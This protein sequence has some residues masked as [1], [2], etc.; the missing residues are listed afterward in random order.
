V[1]AATRTENEDRNK[2]TQQIAQ[3]TRPA[4]RPLILKRPGAPQWPD[5]NKQAKFIPPEH[6]VLPNTCRNGGCLG[7]LEKDCRQI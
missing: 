1:D 3:L 7:H 2:M 5:K 4:S 6:A